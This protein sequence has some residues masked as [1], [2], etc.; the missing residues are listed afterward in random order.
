MTCAKSQNVEVG[1]Y[2]IMKLAVYQWSG[3]IVATVYP[4]SINVGSKE[5]S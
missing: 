2:R 1:Q 3:G 4:S 5:L